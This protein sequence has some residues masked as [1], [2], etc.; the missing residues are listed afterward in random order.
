MKTNINSHNRSS[1]TGITQADSI[2][3]GMDV[4]AEKLVVVRIMDN[5]APQPPQCT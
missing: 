2:K 3:I 4:H 5:G 1:A